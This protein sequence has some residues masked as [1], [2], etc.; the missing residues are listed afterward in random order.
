MASPSLSRSRG[1]PF[2]LIGALLLLAAAHTFSQRLDFLQTAKSASGQVS[3]LDANGSQPLIDFVD[4][5][6]NTVSY[7]QA[8][9][10]FGYQLGM[11]VNV[12]YLPDSPVSSAVID[13]AGA[14]WGSTLLLGLL[15]ASMA[16]AGVPPLR[17]RRWP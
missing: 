2:A 6:G 11:P 7:A 12:R 14:L 4:E 3:A 10:V 1:M 8:G 17:L 16:L 5:R 15:G 9:L 13:D